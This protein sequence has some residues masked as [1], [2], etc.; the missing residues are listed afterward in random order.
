MSAVKEPDD[1]RRQERTVRDDNGIR[2][3]TQGHIRSRSFPVRFDAYGKPDAWAIEWTDTV[4]DDTFFLVNI[5]GMEDVRAEFPEHE[6]T[7]ALPPDITA[8][9]NGQQP[10]TA[11]CPYEVPCATC[12]AAAGEPCRPIAGGEPY[13]HGYVH[14][15]REVLASAGIVPCQHCGATAGQPCVSANGNTRG[16]VHSVRAHAAGRRPA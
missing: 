2:E 15:P 10:T 1:G 5:P 3:V 6:L 11:Q 4:T 12:H 13:E 14:K 16:N 7:G 9:L 8:R